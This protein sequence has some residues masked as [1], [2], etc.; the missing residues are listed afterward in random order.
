MA[1]TVLQAEDRSVCSRRW[2]G[3]HKNSA[4]SDLEEEWMRLPFMDQNDWKQSNTKPFPMDIS[5]HKEIRYL[6]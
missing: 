2:K 1:G 4:C 6:L 5:A 3:E